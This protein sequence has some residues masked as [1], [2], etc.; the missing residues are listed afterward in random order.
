MAV[1][2]TERERTGIVEALRQAAIR[3]AI[4]KGMKKTTVDELAAEAG[5]SKEGGS[6]FPGVKNG[7]GWQF[8]SSRRSLKNEAK[9][10]DFS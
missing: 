6:R 2:F 7:N 4:L 10:L 9:M 1:G 8:D 3:C 5:I